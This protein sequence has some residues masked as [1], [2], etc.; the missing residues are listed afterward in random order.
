[1][2]WFLFVS[3]FHIRGPGLKEGQGHANHLS[4]EASPQLA[5]QHLPSQPHSA[6]SRSPQL[7]PSASLSTKV[8]DE[9]DAARWTTADKGALLLHGDNDHL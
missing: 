8:G 9:L 7:V 2:R 6:R 4:L 1:M 3:Y 5:P